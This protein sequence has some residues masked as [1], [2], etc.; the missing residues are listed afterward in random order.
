MRRISG[1]LGLALLLAPGISLAQTKEK[2]QQQIATGTCECIDKKLAARPTGTPLAKEEANQVLVQCMM[3]ASG[4]NLTAIQSIY[5]TEAFTDKEV[6][7]QLGREVAGVMMQSCANFTTLSLA[8]ANKET[9]ST[10][11]TTGQTTGQLGLLRGTE[12]G[13]LELQVSKT[14][15]AT[16]VWLHRFA[17]AEELLP[18]LS[19][20]QGR[21]VR[22]SWQEVELFQPSTRQYQRLREITGISLL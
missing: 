14:E 18:Q 20:L 4:K 6:M 1:L 8:I 12:A 21:Q 3:A 17:G 22:V 15:K 5:G 7:R 2:L 19:Q 11:A 13:T 9:P 16:F 10:A